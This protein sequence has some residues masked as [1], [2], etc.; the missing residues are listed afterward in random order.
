LHLHHGQ[1][2]KSGLGGQY[3]G[4]PVVWPLGIVLYCIGFA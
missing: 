1:A 4:K 2:S 3:L